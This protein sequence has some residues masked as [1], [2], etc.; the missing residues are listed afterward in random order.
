MLALHSSSLSKFLMSS[1]VFSELIAS[2]TS[3][4]VNPLDFALASLAQLSLLRSAA[5]SISVNHS[6]NFVEFCSL[7]MA[8][9]CSRDLEKCVCFC[10]VHSVSMFWHTTSPSG[11][12]GVRVEVD[13]VLSVTESVCSSH[14]RCSMWSSPSAG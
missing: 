4:H 13:C 3:V 7:K 6:S 2:M 10:A 5:V 1:L 8:M 9:P 11:Y 12:E 14:S